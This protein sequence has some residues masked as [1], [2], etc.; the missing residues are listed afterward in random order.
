MDTLDLSPIAE[1]RALLTAADIR[2]AEDP[3]DLTPPGVLVRLTGFR[4]HTLGAP[5]APEVTV[6]A[7]VPEANHTRATANL[8]ALVDQL[9]V[10]VDPDGDITAT[11]VELS[12]G[13]A[14]A[15]A[16]AFPLHLY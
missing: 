2:N 13:A 3:A 1:L 7:I 5:M 9:L 15:P 12:Q 10:L 11:S 16:F 6:F 8:V 14:P 4:R